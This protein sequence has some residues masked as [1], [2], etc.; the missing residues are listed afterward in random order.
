MSDC[1]LR[2]PQ[3]PNPRD[4]LARATQQ[5]KELVQRY[6]DACNVGDFEAVFACLHPNCIHHSR[7]SEYP[8]NG[9]A[10]AFKSTF[11][12]FPDLHWTIEELIAEGERVAALVLIEGTHV[13]DYLGAS[14]TGRRIRV[15]SV[16]IARVR[17]GL[18]V[19]HRGVLDELHLL[20]QVG[21]VPETF[22]AQMS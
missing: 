11:A 13:G 22:L 8:K 16:D 1:P 5:T 10:F 2:N 15:H 19:E 18:F 14:G 7:L 20:A 12:A 21:V 9:V 6:Y 3:P 4:N 17:D